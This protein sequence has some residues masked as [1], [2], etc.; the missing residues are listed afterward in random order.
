LPEPEFKLISEG[1]QV[2][3]FVDKY[4]SENNNYPENYPEK[5]TEKFTE[6][7]EK[8]TEN[9]EKFTENLKNIL[10]LI[11]DNPTI[12]FDELSEKIGISR[13]AIIKNTNKLKQLGLLKR[14]GPDKGGYW[15]INKE[16]LSN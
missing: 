15:K 11:E 1:F 2:T 13:R 7:T 3:V 4:S 12:S 6:N 16:K 5:A 14:I 8:F 10:E 9:I